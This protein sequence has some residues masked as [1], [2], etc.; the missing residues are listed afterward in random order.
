MQREH[1]VAAR[2]TLEAFVKTPNGLT[3]EQAYLML[4]RLYL[5]SGLARQALFNLLKAYD[6][7]PTDA[8]IRASLA[9]TYKNLGDH[10]NE[11]EFA[12]LTAQIEPDSIEY[13]TILV[14]AL[15]ANGLQDE[16]DQAARHALATTLE[17]YKE[18]P[19]DFNRL[20][21]LENQINFVIRVLLGHLQS[22]PTQVD[23]LLELADLTDSYSV[24]QQSARNYNAMRYVMQAEKLRPN[25]PKIILRKAGY[26]RKVLR[27]KDAFNSYMKVLALDPNNE[28]ALKWTAKIRQIVPALQ[29]PVQSD[30][31]AE[32]TP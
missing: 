20:Q 21:A 7:N 25:D 8:E 26:E 18:K 31:P 30:E 14:G 2:I 9:V 16:A 32:A 29:K 23:L 1:Y 3:S 17:K 6:L 4:G 11:L 10:E 15:L 12:R 28:E 13:G 5:E 22:E 24:V 19:E 27:L